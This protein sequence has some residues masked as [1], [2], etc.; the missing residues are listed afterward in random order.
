MVH[1]PTSE[2]EANR[3]VHRRR[4]LLPDL[5]GLMLADR[6]PHADR[7][8]R[9]KPGCAYQLGFERLL[10]A[11]EERPAAPPPLLSGRQVMALLGVGPGPSLGRSY[12]P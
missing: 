9:R 3:F 10:T 2:R 4:E 6:K 8:V 11:L 1:L 12:A 5:L 7:R